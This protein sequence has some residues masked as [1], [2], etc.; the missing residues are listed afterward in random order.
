MRD[1]R[2]KSIAI[3]IMTT[4][5]FIVTCMSCSPVEYKKIPL[6]S[7]DPKLKK[8]GNIIAQDILVSIRHEEGVR[9]LLN[10]N[11]ITPMVHGRI[12][13]NLDTYQESYTITA[14]FLGEVSKISLFQVIDKKIIKTL[15]YK[16]YADTVNL[17]FIELKIDINNEYGLADFYLYITTS[18]GKLKRKNILPEFKK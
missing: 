15:R 13:H 3:R 11:Y 17:E 2:L 5:L 6:D 12:M 14:L 18:D 10:K 4:M 9:Y 8:I 7:M 16:L 1:K